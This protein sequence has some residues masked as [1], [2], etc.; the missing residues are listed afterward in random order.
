MEVVSIGYVD[1]SNIQNT[2]VSIRAKGILCQ[3]ENNYYNMLKLN[4][5]R[6]M[7]SVLCTYTDIF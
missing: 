2:I 7:I 3:T 5:I 6:H 1:S 4:K